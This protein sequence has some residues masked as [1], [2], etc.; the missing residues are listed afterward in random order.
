MKYYLKLIA[1]GSFPGSPDV[2]IKE[3]TEAEYLELGK[4]FCRWLDVP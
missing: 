3:I 2:D 4:R 1:E